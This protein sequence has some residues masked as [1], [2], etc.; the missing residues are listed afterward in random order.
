[1]QEQVSVTG[2]ILKAEPA[3]EYDRRVVILT[4][5]RGKLTAFA[6]RQE[7]GQQAVGSHRS[8]LLWKISALRGAER[9]QHGRGCDQ[10][11]F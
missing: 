6:R 4:K 9:I 7:T 10:Q 11:L 2:M 8:F 1:M 3:G 5:E